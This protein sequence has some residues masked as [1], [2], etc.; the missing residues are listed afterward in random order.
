MPATKKT[1]TKRRAALKSAA[2]P[3]QDT[4]THALGEA[5]WA[6]A[7]A[8]L[9]AA[10]ADLDDVEAAIAGNAAAGDALFMVAQALNRVA[11]KRG[12]MRFGDAGAAINFDPAQHELERTG[13]TA[14][15][16][17][18]VLRA[19]VIRAGVVL[20]KARVAPQRTAKKA[21]A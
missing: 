17:V 14:P 19:G 21:R 11:R 5:A 16:Q 18:R 12:M 2:V 6:E 13:G 15:K 3:R 4:L 7:D 10:L 9:A 20:V 1:T 8:S